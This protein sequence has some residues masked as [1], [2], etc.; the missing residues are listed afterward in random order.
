MPYRQDGQH[1]LFHTT[2]WSFSNFNRLSAST[3]SSLNE[4]VLLSDL[5]K[6]FLEVEEAF[7]ALGSFHF[8]DYS[9]PCLL[10]DFIHENDAK[11]VTVHFSQIYRSP[12]LE[13]F[14]HVM[15]VDIY[16]C[17]REFEYMAVYRN[18]AAHDDSS[19]LKLL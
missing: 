18:T 19:A 10:T 1:F 16:V 11:I 17:D 7:Y 14:P 8:V 4:D 15:S 12:D 2:F 13:K 9:E 3:L 5:V 6:M